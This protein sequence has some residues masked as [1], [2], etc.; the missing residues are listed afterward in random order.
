M[1]ASG[2]ASRDRRHRC[3]P[4]GARHQLPPDATRARAPRA[5]ARAGRRDLEIA[6]LGRLRPQHAELGAATSGVS[7]PGARPRQLRAARRGDRI[8]GGLCA[9]VR[10]AR[11]ER[12][13]RHARATRRRPVPGGDVRRRRRDLERRRRGR[14]L[15]A[16][17]SEPARG[18]G[19]GRAST[20][21][22]RASTAAPSSFP[23]EAS[24]SSAAASPVAR[25]RRSS[26]QPAE[27]CISRS[28]AAPG[29]RVDTAAARSSTG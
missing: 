26:S 4:G 14:R 15:P 7:L 29:S 17:D 28:D 6:A 5:R 19:A 2:G 8:P 21:C 20:S 11:L 13:K 3:G 27:R 25:S 22:T 18:E 16:P 10:R 24:S 12:R 9:V 1:V 23:R